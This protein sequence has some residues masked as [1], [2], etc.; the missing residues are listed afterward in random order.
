ML[1][2]V[3]GAVVAICT[4]A[5]TAGCSAT[6]TK[7]LRVE[8]TGAIT[9]TPCRNGAVQCATLEVP[10]DVAHPDGERI[11]LALARRPASGKRIG[12]L[13]TNP[14]GP[15]ASGIQFLEDA[16]GVFRPEI[17][18]RF[19]IVSWDPRGVGSSAPIRCL[20]NLDAFYAVDRTPENAEAVARNVAVAR[21]FV[22]SCK[23]RS[24]HELGDVSTSAG[25][26][27]MDAI[28]AAIGE[29]RISYMG[30]SY[31][32]FLGAR[33]AD[34]YPQ[35][36]RTMVLDG[37]VDPSL[38]Y[39]AGTIAQARGFEE[40]LAAFFAWCRQDPRCGFARGGDPADAF[41]RLERVVAAEPTPGTVNGEERTLGPGE[42]DIAVATGLYAGRAGFP[43]LADALVDTARGS[44]D[45]MLVL[46]DEY[47]ERQPG[48]KYSNLTAAFY[49]TSCVDGPSARTV[50]DV[51]RLA[52]RAARVAP[53]FGAPSAWLGLPCTFWPVPPR[54]KPAAVHA[55]GAPPLLVVGTTH[56]PA[57]PYAW[58]QS[59]AAQLRTG[60]LLTF[61][62]DGHTA[63][64]RGSSCI[65]DAVDDY[66]L[67]GTVPAEGTR[68]P[69]P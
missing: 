17:L 55:E 2:A 50:A 15:G 6:G 38:S 21:E 64:A 11:S 45:Q 7:T 37:A 41:D 19:D 67:A 49:A 35:H 26:R 24:G 16:A 54:D 1:R 10:L 5:L 56:D 31:G 34:A 63:Y 44:G 32:T 23:Q 3:R 68:C 62:G 61:E 28:R 25:V 18:R 58:A 69:A 42:F 52:D 33:Y 65:D 27:D 4:A 66:L 53:H 12:V 51:Q 48:G 39:A 14:G 59:L 9:W 57:T 40:L 46:A 13:L 29:A 60:H 47:T 22:A 20:D 8:H 36:V 30:F 43:V